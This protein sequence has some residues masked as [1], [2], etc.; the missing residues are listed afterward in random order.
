MSIDIPTMEQTN[1]TKSAKL[2]S[3][4]GLR[5]DYQT[6]WVRFIAYAT[7]WK[8]S[9]A[10]VTGGETTM[11]SSDAAVLDEMT[12]TGKASTAAKQRNA[13]AMANL[14]MAFETEGLLGIVYKSTSSRWPA[15]LAHEVVAQLQKKYS[16][17][18]RISRVELRTMLNAVSMKTT[19]DPSVL[20][21]QVSAI[22]NRYDTAAHQIDEEELIAVI[23][24]AAPKEFISVITSEQRARGNQMTLDDL[25]A[26]MYHI[27]T[28]AQGG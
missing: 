6:W 10:L 8:F 9:A 13:L 5:K 2:P 15:G 27:G 1:P 16:P 25:E 12:V 17:D 22:R 11:P 21:E 18:D 7:V 14:T 20:F 3:F 24:G 19:E 23:M 26:V 28:P 4:S